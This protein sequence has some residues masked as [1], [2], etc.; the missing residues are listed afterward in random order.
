MSISWMVMGECIAF[1]VC[2]VR[3]TVPIGY[4]ICIIVIY[5]YDSV[6]ASLLTAHL[7]FR[8]H[9]SLTIIITNTNP[10]RPPCPCKTHKNRHTFAQIHTYM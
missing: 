1:T 8:L 4:P 2:T 6:C 9:T 7:P 3:Y 5:C 10:T